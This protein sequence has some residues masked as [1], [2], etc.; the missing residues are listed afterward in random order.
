M[1]DTTLKHSKE[2]LDL[3]NN[4]GITQIFEEENIR[5]VSDPK[6]IE[7]IIDIVIK[8]NQQQVNKY[9]SG[10]TKVFGFLAGETMKAAKGKANPG[11]VNKILKEKLG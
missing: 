3:I 9:K 7:E 5:Q 10:E 6:I 1:N 11:L 2:I 4:R 8:N